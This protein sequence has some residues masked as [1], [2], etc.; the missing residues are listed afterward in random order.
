LSFF[1]KWLNWRILALVLFLFMITEAGLNS[2][3]QLSGIK[4]EWN[5]ASRKYYNTQTN[6]INPLVTNIHS[7]TGK[8]FVRTENTVPDTAND[9]MKYNYNALSQFSS[10]RNSNSSKVMGLLGF[11]TDSTYLNLRYPENT[12][13]MDSLLSI[14]Y[15][16]NQFQPEKYGFK[17]IKP[18]L[19]ENK[20][21]QSLGLFVQGAFKDV[22]LKK[23]EKDIIPNQEAFLNQLTNRKDKYF[24]QFYVD[25]ETSNS[26]ISGSKDQVT[27]VRKVGEDGGVSVTYGITVPA[28]S[29]AYLE[30]P[31]VSY[32]NQN[33]RT[34]NI[35]ISSGKKV[36]HAYN[37]NSNDVGNF[38][39]LGKFDKETKVQVSI[40]FPEN[41]QVSFKTTRFLALN[42]DKYQA[43][44]DSLKKADVKTEQTKN[45]VTLTY[46]TSQSGQIFLTLPY[47]K[48]WSAKL[49][50]K[51]VR[52]D[53]AQEG[54]MKVNAPAG[55]HKVE[56][57]FFPQGLKAGI[58][59]FVA[60]LLLF[61]GYDFLYRKKQH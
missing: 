39:N 14:H 52:L 33:S 10:V 44:M 42:I 20:N 27:L 36:L 41:S 54:F 48:G 12:L 45:G 3:Y 56:L 46:N 18:S 30:L 43:A 17:Q 53:K 21:A 28:R 7:R 24:T 15:N 55:Q 29:Q 35:T 23:S 6:F 9:G 4:K 26:T 31:D 58:A 49:D 13:I 38:Y 16:I 2:Y 50:G 40:S 32:L 19:F 1:K 37:V 60:G 25:S 47:D 59:C 61:V 8:A 11:H 51:T 34:T 5:F 22:N 57:H